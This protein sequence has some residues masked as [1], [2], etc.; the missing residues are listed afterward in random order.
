MPRNHPDQVEKRRFLGAQINRTGIEMFP[1]S[2]CKKFNQEY[3][4]SPE[5]S[6][7]CCSK[8]VIL[9]HCYDVVTA[10]GNSSSRT[11]ALHSSG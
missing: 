11:M 7:K 2:Y 5:E 9:G 3:V 6:S 8:Y 4:V 10:S 1:C